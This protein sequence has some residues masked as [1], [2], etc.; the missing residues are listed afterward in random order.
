MRRWSNMQDI[1]RRIQSAT[2]PATQYAVNYLNQNV[3]QPLQRGIQGFANPQAPSGNVAQRALDQIP[4]LKNI[5]GF[6]EGMFGQNAVNNPQVQVEGEMGLKALP[7]YL[8]P[9]K[10]TDAIT[11]ARLYRAINRDGNIPIPQTQKVIELANKYNI[12]PKFGIDKIL[13]E[14]AG[15]LEPHQKIT[16]K[17]DLSF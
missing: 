5:R 6:S 7:P 2:I 13:G 12:D 17:K 4:V 15:A 3:S 11:I 10:N 16:L 14:L 8:N 9:I 1:A